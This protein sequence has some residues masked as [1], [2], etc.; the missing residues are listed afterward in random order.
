MAKTSTF[1]NY[2]SFLFAF[3]LGIFSL[4]TTKA[5]PVL[6]L[7]PVISSGLNAPLQFV[8]AGDGSNRIF[9]VQQGGTIRAYDASFNFLSTFVTVSGV[10]SQGGERGLLSLAFHPEYASN[11]LFYVYYVNTAGSLE[12]ARY[13]V[14]ADPNVVDP[15]SKVVMKTIPHPTNTNHNGGELHF[16]NDGFLYLSTGDG[17][18]AGD[19]PNNA[20]NTSVLLGKILRFNVNNPNPPYYSIPA[21]NPYGNEIFALGLRNPFRWSFDSQT[22]D[23]WIGDVGQD[24][25]EEVDY[26]AAASTTGSNFGWHCYEANNEFI[27]TGC[28]PASN[29]V[30]PVYS[31]PTQD[32]SAAVTGGVVYRGS[33]YS[34]LQGYYLSVDFFSGVFHKIIPNGAG[35]WTTTTQTLAP[36]GI[37]DFGET[38]NGEVYVVSL[39]SNA[40]YHV[41]SS[42][43]VPVVLQNFAATLN[44]DGVN[45]NWQT[46]MEQNLREF[47]IEYSNDAAIF[48]RLSSVPALNSA[49]GHRY[50]FVDVTNHDA[51]IFYRLKMINEN[52]SYVY[53]NTVRISLN[54]LG[55]NMITPTVITDGVVHINLTT[56]GYRLVELIR[57]DGTL[58]SKENIEGRTGEIKIPVGNLARG[59]YA[60]RLTG[61]SPTI[62][63]KIYIN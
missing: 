11:G 41:Q 51:V 35:G 12:L 4:K 30:F 14:S 58:V 53:S 39:T 5:Q 25:F 40:V 32:P 17:G 8:N 6:S 33:V 7:S 54:N 2:K 3:L 27:T 1:F 26:R 60:V 48:T 34:D 43:P 23:M 49:S 21:G 42:G 16:G 10:N 56:D 62:L 38:E 29:Y 19:Q 20:Q 44:T 36:T 37:A 47:E 15:N 57:M 59:I 24:N 45:L 50:K 63:Q 46:S 31:Y 13:H 61:T 18:G 52:G 22:Y 28:G 9:I 55:R